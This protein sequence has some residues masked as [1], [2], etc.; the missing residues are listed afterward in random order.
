M[1]EAVSAGLVSKRLGVLQQQC[2]IPP[3]GQ[4]FKVSDLIGRYSSLT[5]YRRYAELY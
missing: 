3:K 1:R 5:V 2:A 4:R